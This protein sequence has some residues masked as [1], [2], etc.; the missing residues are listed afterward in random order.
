MLRVSQDKDADLKKIITETK[1]QIQK[2][3]SIELPK[4]VIK[5]TTPL[6]PKSPTDPLPPAK[7][8]P[9]DD[10]REFINQDTISET[11][12]KFILDFDRRYNYWFPVYSDKSVLCARAKLVTPEIIR[13]KLTNLELIH[14]PRK[15]PNKEQVIS[16]LAAVRTYCGSSTATV[17]ALEEAYTENYPF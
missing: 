9:V 10:S 6:L 4:P 1:E 14:A 16:T 15:V 2:D 12:D 11:N 7:V 3:E 13:Q 8:V 5:T 17:D